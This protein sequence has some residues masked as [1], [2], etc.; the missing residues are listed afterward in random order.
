MTA[1]R[2]GLGVPDSLLVPTTSLIAV[3]NFHTGAPWTYDDEKGVGLALVTWG[4]EYDT[5]VK[6]IIILSSFSH[7]FYFQDCIIF[8]K[9]LSNQ[10]RRTEER[11]GK[12]NFTNQF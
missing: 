9:V 3:L 1:G 10:N 11:N 7:H 5:S 6:I 8:V 4:A 2:K 12:T